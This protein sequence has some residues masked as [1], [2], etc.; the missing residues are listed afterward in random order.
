MG[1]VSS[2]K[3]FYPLFLFLSLSALIFYSGCVTPPKEEVRKSQDIWERDLEGARFPLVEEI[4]LYPARWYG[5][6][7]AACS[8]TFDDGTLDQFTLGA[9]EMDRQGL[10]GTFFVIT[11]FME[12]EIWKDGNTER[13]L[14]NWDQARDL[15]WRGHEIASHTARHLDLSANPGKVQTEIEEALQDLKREIPWKKSFSLGWPYWRSSKEA[16]VIASQFHFAARAGGISAQPGSSSF[17]GVNG[18]SPVNFMGIG[19]HGILPSDSRETLLPIL[20][21]VYENGGWLIPNFHGLKDGRIPTKAL[22][23]QPLPLETFSLILETLKRY[24]LWFAPFGEVA[25]YAQQRDSIT[26]ETKRVGY[27]WRADYKSNLDPDIYN[28]PLTLNLEIP[29]ETALLL[30][31]EDTTGRILPFTLKE[32]NERNLYLLDLPSGDGTLWISLGRARE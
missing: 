7:K 21:E 26:L 1:K 2:Q 23:W 20:K 29:A 16:E 30:V 6:R 13:E 19:S 22:G 31:M 28:Q 32:R 14:F 5:N 12:K 24:D 10:R 8:I 27:L 15:A 11:G 18:K 25:K 3:E 9:P 4:R 17:G